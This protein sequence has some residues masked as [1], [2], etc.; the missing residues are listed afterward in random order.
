MS[1]DTKCVT[2][3]KSLNFVSLN[4]YEGLKLE[5]FLSCTQEEICFLSI[6]SQNFKTYILE[7]VIHWLLFLLEKNFYIWYFAKII[8]IKKDIYDVFLKNFAL[9][10]VGKSGETWNVSE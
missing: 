9:L 7:K 8:S 4:F 1:T 10:K 2:S 5:L 3:S 6:R